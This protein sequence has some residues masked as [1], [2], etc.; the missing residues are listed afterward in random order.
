MPSTYTLNNGIELIGTGEQSGTWGD[1]TNLNFELLDTALDGQVTITLASAGTS[2]SPNDLPISDGSSSNGRNRL[3]IFNDGGDLGATAFVQLTPNDAEKIIYVRN[4]LSGSRDLTLFQGTY[5]AS[6]DYVVP[7]GTTAVVFF[8]GAG[9]GAVAANVFNNAHFDALNVAGSAVVASLTATTA[10]INGGTIDGTVIGG[11]T[12][13]AGSFTTG[14]FTGD[15]SFGD[16]NKAIFGAGSDLQIYHDGANSLIKDSGTGHIKILANDFRLQNVTESQAMIAADQGGAVTLYNNGSPKL[17]T[18]STGI[19]VT[20]TV[21]ADGLTVSGA[22]GTLA[23][24]N[25]VGSNGVYLNLADNSGSNVFLGNSGGQFQVQTSGSSYANKMTVEANGDISFYED[26]GTTPKFF[27]DASAEQ[28]IV[29]GST[30]AGDAAADDLLIGQGSGN[31]GLSIYSGASSTGNLFFKDSSSNFAGYV[32]YDHSDNSMRLGTSTSPRMTIDSSGSVGIGT[33][34]PDTLLHLD[35][36]TS[37]PE[38]RLQ[39]SSLTSNL[40]GF[41]LD[42]TGARVVTSSSSSFPLAFDVNGSEAMRIDASGNLLVSGTSNTAFSDT[43]GS[44]IGLMDNGGDSFVAISRSNTASTAYCMVLNRTATTDGDILTFRKQ[45]STVG[46]IG[47]RAGTVIYITSNGT[48][49]TGLDFGGTSVNPM[50]SGSLSNGTTDLGNAGNRFK[51]L[52]LSGGLR[53]DTTFK[54]NAGTTE[55]ARFD[56]SG[57]LGIGE[58]NPNAQL[59]V[60]SGTANLTALF[61]SEDVTASL[62]LVDSSTTGGTSA[63]HGLV[64]TGNE[65]SVRGISNLSF[66]TGATEQVIINSAGALLV[67]KTAS[68]TSVDGFEAQKSGT[69]G[70]SKSGGIVAVFNRNTNDGQIVAL[71]QNGTTEGNIS[72]SGTT[73]SYNGGHLARWAQTT[74]NTRISGLVKGTVLTNLDQM[75]AWGDEDNE[76]LNCLAVSSVEGDPNVAGV[77][78]NWDDDDE[79]YTADMNIAMTGDMIIRVAQGTTV[80]RGDLLMSAGDGTAKP[81]GDDIVRSKTIAKV[82]STHVSNT[83]DDGSYCVPCVLMAC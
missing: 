33:S 4:D 17:A 76:Q 15:V 67:G 75:A 61:E 5:N 82:T 25:R 44:Q 36:G 3:I 80:Q 26:T 1:T 28:L 72:V 45:G 9:S 58:S 30:A 14:S 77:F 38:I 43:S 64:T 37:E 39:A 27:W 48:N 66:R 60:N 65:L 12:P 79:D 51:D 7:A 19:D 32:Q 63:V 70:A 24:L 16:N 49:E 74:D 73:V 41:K 68:N 11:T 20:G 83:Y 10:D 22:S 46:S 40:A 59:H 56:S 34:S 52:H 62:Y 23:T 57:N 50:L 29:G 47:S 42:T 2:G 69:I 71:R 8:N 54:N 13:A 18:T 53:G 35:G 6:N 78:V 31:Q 21:T 55:Y 81:Q